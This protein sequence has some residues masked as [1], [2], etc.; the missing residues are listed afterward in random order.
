MTSQREQLQA[1]IAEID[2][3]LSKASPKLPWVAAQETAQQRQVLSKARECLQ[4]LTE[5]VALP[6]PL[7][8]LEP[9]RS[10]QPVADQAS[11]SSVL[12]ALLQEMQYLR[13]QMVQP[14]R[15]EIQ[16][17]QQ[18]RE[19][20]QQQVQQL[21]RDRQQL[22]SS[23][24]LDYANLD[25]LFQAL[26]ERLEAQVKAQIEQSV[27]RLDTEISQTYLLSDPT[28]SAPELGSQLPP[29]NTHPAASAAQADSAAVRRAGAQP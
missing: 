17:L 6:G 23:A 4:V 29:A 18:E 28:T 22:Q 7:S 26:A 3:L 12:Q 11:A 16:T 15:S 8:E 27:Q 1:L 25:Q 2:V 21:E 20:L 14:L 10:L 24:S 13:S 9:A 5:T 19:S